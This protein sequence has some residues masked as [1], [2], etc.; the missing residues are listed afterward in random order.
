MRTYVDYK[1]KKTIIVL[2]II[3]LVVVM[4]SS[5]DMLVENLMQG[6]IAEKQDEK[7]INIIDPDLVNKIDAFNEDS[8]YPIVE[9]F[10]WVDNLG[11]KAIIQKVYEDTNRIDCLI[12]N[13]N[14]DFTHSYKGLSCYTFWKNWTDRMLTHGYFNISQIIVENDAIALGASWSSDGTSNGYYIIESYEI[15][16]LGKN[17]TTPDGQSFNDCLETT[18]TIEYPEGYDWRKWLMEVKYYF[19][20]GIGMVM[21]KNLWSDGSIETFYLVKSSRFGE[22]VSYDANGAESGEVPDGDTAYIS[23]TP[24]TVLGNSGDLEKKDYIFSNWNT[25]AD[26]SGVAYEKGSE[27]LMGEED[28]TLY[29]QWEK[30]EHFNVVGWG[31]SSICT[32]VD[33]EGLPVFM[34]SDRELFGS[35]PDGAL[36]AEDFS[37][38]IGSF[39]HAD[40]SEENGVYTYTLYFTIPEAG[41]FSVSI[42]DTAHDAVGNPVIAKQLHGRKIFEVIVPEAEH[43]HISIDSG[44]Y[45]YGKLEFTALP[46]TDY[47]FSSWTGYPDW[48]ASVSMSLNQNLILPVPNFEFDHKDYAVGTKGPAGGYIFYDDEADGI[49]DISGYRYLEA[50][51]YGWYDTD[52]DLV[53]LEDDDPKFEWARYLTPIGRTEADLGAGSNNTSIIVNALS[54]GSYAA[55]ICDDY[56]LTVKG[57]V[58]D[59][60]FLPSQDELDLIFKNLKLNE[61]GGFSDYWYWS[62]TEL[63][64]DDA[65]LLDFTIDSYP[66]PPQSGTKTN[67]MRVRPI[68]A[69]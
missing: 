60:W 23:G 15:T 49:D 22:T 27:F 20:K 43:G 8:Y 57:E 30:L 25:A 44:L 38:S 52:G 39:S 64:S 61:L 29:A 59:S 13:E 32:R 24:V 14:G 16:S 56:S 28:I 35:G 51:P 9:G 67:M 11:N 47:L 34:E 1:N 21:A 45:A 17:I 3:L 46:D 2:L 4:I 54:S 50:A 66:P 62:S 10:Y 5:C 63:E 41:Q 6:S 18:R 33:T 53:Y 37:C 48:E 19:Q 42:N 36:S 69:F 12:E 26:G 65:R 55:K 7:V 40:M 31:T 68:R 58:F